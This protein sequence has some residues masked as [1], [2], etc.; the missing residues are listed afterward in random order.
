MQKTPMTLTSR[1]QDGGGALHLLAMTKG[2]TSHVPLPAE[3]RS[4]VRAD[5][6]YLLRRLDCINLELLRGDFMR[7]TLWNTTWVMNVTHLTYPDGPMRYAALYDFPPDSQRRPVSVRALSD[8][9]NVPYETVRRNLVALEE[10]GLCERVRGE[11]VFIPTSVHQRPQN[12]EG[13]RML[14][15]LIHKFLAELKRL[16][17][18]FT[19]FREPAH[20]LQNDPALVLRAAL[21]VDT[22]YSLE[23]ADLLRALHK[24]TPVELAIYGAI[25][26]PNTRGIAASSADVPDE[27]RRPI[28]GL[29]LSHTLRV[30]YETLRRVSNVMVREGKLERVKDGLIVP[31]RVQLSYETDD[32]LRA[33][34][35]R[36]V[37]YV[38]DLRHIGIT[39]PM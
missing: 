1:T 24:A 7:A 21:R 36:L 38:R 35:E 32:V 25:C 4:I 5:D 6:E 11:G 17:F 22:D 10:Q 16:G 12:V 30:P 23:M 27:Q 18:D 2:V 26:T 20:P 34:Y 19:Q 28:S 8:R 9:L 33:R 15:G 39:M 37:R 31:L 3:I 14:G 29:A 13:V